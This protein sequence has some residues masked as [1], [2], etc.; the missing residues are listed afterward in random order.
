LRLIVDG[1]SNQETADKLTISN[2]AVK[3]I[4]DTVLSKLALDHRTQSAVH[5]MRHS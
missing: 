4:L 1:F 5:T 3:T 2:A